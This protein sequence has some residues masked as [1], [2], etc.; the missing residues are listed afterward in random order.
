LSHAEAVAQTPPKPTSTFS[1]GAPTPAQDDAADKAQPEKEQGQGDKSWTP[2]TP[3]KFG[4]PT[5]NESTTPATAPPAKS[6]FGGGLFGPSAVPSTTGK[7]APPTVGFNFGAPKGVSTDVS[8]ATT[9]GVTTDDGEAEGGDGEASDKPTG[10]Q[11]ED[12]TAILPEERETE[13]ILFEVPLAKAMKSERDPDTNVS[14]WVDKGKGPLYIFKNKQTGKTRV[15]MKI[16]PLGRPAM[17][18]GPVKGFEYKWSGKK[19]LSGTFFDHISKGEDGSKPSSWSLMV[20][21]P[22]DAEAIA[23]VLEENKA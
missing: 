16:P 15:V 20:R 18:F 7:L 19:T 12:M 9:P 13:D 17:N 23:R 8:R 6:M 4:A 1:F 10:K 14:K 22:S 11:V 3:I 21:E 2:A 5:G